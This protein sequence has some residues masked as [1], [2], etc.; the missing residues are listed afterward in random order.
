MNLFTSFHLSSRTFRWRTLTTTC[1]TGAAPGAAS[2]APRSTAS[3]RTLRSSFRWT[4]RRTTYS[5]TPCGKRWST[6]TG[7]ERRSKPSLLSWRTGRRLRCR[8]LRVECR[9]RC[10]IRLRSR[11]R[12]DPCGR[13]T[14]TLLV[15]KSWPNWTYSPWPFALFS[16]SCSSTL[17][18]CQWCSWSRTRMV[19]L[20]ILMSLILELSNVTLCDRSLSILKFRR[21]EL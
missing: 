12:D 9:P 20:T 5:S 7:T 11:S 16:S 18:F 3:T 13:L 4:R 10:L 14:P 19:R 8:C 21:V 2:P 15:Y 17:A 6:C 1:A